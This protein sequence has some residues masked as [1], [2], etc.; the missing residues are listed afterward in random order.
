MRCNCRVC[1]V[2]WNTQDADRLLGRHRTHEQHVL[3]STEGRHILIDFLPVLL[4]NLISKKWSPQSLSLKPHYWK[5]LSHLE[6]PKKKKKSVK[7]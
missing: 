7:M 2:D 6:A 3:N 4:K 1:T 5:Y